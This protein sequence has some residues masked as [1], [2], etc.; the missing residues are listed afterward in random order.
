M[1]LKKNNTRFFW[2]AV[3]PPSDFDYLSVMDSLL[4]IVNYTR[5]DCVFAVSC[6]AR[7]S[8]NYDKLYV[9]TVKRVV[10]YLFHTRHMGIA[11]FKEK[12]GFC[13]N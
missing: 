9:D 3:A 8:I 5:P 10:K 11:Y 7:H 6:L 13:T 4:Y 12:E 1:E 2:L